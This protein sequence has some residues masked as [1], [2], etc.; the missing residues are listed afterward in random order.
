[1]S[2]KR[3]FEKFE[4]R[5]EPVTVSDTRKVDANHIFLNLPFCGPILKEIT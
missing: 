4:M 5:Q 3:L 2:I 1:M